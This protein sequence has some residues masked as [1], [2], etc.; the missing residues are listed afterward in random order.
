MDS[1]SVNIGKHNSIKTRIEGKYS[2]VYT[3]GCPCHFIHNATHHATKSLEASCGFDVEGTVVDVFYYFDHSTKRKG[4]LQDFATFCNVES[5]KIL[6]YVSTRWLSLQA[7]V[8]R[9]L[10]QYRPLCSYFLS[11]DPK[12]S[13]NRLNRLQ[14]CFSNPMTEIYLLFFQS[15]LSIFGSI[16]FR[17]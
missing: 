1:A 2:P 6:K 17:H 15:I 4:E 16:S 3:L 5:C 11:Q 9:I 13:D 8:E 7:S 14:K 10:K 12:L